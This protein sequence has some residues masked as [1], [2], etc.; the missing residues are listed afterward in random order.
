MFQRMLRVFVFHQI[1]S[2]TNLKNVFINFNLLHDL[3]QRSCDEIEI[4]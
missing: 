3:F 1:D 4:S 2:L